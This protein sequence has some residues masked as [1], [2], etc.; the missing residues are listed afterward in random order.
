MP[1]T[2]RRRRKSE[3]DGR[4]GRFVPLLTLSGGRIRRESIR[5]A[6]PSRRCHQRRAATSAQTPSTN[7]NGHP[8]SPAAVGFICHGWSLSKRGRPGWRF[9]DLSGIWRLSCDRRQSWPELTDEVV[10]YAFWHKPR[11]SGR[12]GKRRGWGSKR[13]EP[14]VGL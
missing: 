6:R 10:W 13:L 7:P 1:P 2:V 14:V 8:P 3:T 4:S 5:Y 12:F 11:T 9:G